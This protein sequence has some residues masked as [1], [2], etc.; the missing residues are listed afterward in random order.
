M[1]SHALEVLKGFYPSNTP[2]LRDE[3]RPAPSAYS[4][5]ML[6]NGSKGYGAYVVPFDGQNALGEMGQPI[7]YTVDHGTLTIRSWQLYLESNNYKTILKKLR[8]T[9]VGS[10]LT[11]QCQPNFKYLQKKGINMDQDAL[12]EYNNDVESIWFLCANST[13]FDYADKDTL[14]ELHARAYLNSIAGGDVLVILR[15]VNNVVKVQLVDGVHVQTPMNF[16][17]AMESKIGFE[18]LE[19]INPDNN[20][21]VRWGIEID[22]TGRH[23]A[24]HVRLVALMPTC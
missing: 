2:V 13:M 7:R 10:G 17:V 11:L 5:G 21:R 14:G 22:A 18:F 6:G 16:P 9:V 24:Y 23:I 15:V 1:E 4:E 8:D 19:R 12:E 20:N 3:T